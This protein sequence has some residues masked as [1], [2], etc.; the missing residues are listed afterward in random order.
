MFRGTGVVRFDGGRVEHMATLFDYDAVDGQG[1]NDNMDVIVRGMEFEGVRGGSDRVFV[2]GEQ[3]EGATLGTNYGLI[4]QDCKF[5]GFY[6]VVDDVPV[7]G[8]SDL[9]FV[10]YPQ[11]ALRCTFERCRFIGIRSLQTTNV[12]PDLVRCFKNDYTSDGATDYKTPLRQFEQATGAPVV[13]TQSLRNAWQD[14]PWVQTGARNNVLGFS[15]FQGQD[16]VGR[17]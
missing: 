7:V 2:N 4:V 14:T 16:P 9:N 10:S 8:N 12:R 17:R 15:D 1:A 13:R 11:D 5:Q 3:T 6:R